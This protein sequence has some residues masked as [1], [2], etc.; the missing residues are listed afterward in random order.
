M[1]LDKFLEGNAKRPESEKKRINSE[2][3]KVQMPWIRSMDNRTIQ[4]KDY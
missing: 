1:V 3:V 4:S 2:D